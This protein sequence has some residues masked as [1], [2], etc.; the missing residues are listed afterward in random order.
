MQSCGQSSVIVIVTIHPKER[1]PN[2]KLI[3][4]DVITSVKF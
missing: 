3:L 2:V 1:F 4:I